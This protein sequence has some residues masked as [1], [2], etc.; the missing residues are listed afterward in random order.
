MAYLLLMYC[1]SRV[2]MYDTSAG[3]SLSSSSCSL[4]HLCTECK[5][6]YIFRLFVVER[7]NAQPKYLGNLIIPVY[8]QAAYLSI[9][10]ELLYQTVRSC[11]LCLGL[12]CV[13]TELYTNIISNRNFCRLSVQDFSFKIALFM[14][15]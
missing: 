8:E 10:N 14:S 3:T 2:M 6:I 9:T 12:K 4:V 7:G 5:I 15:R 1:T 13:K 11:R